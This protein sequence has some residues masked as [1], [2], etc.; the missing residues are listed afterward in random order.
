M[1]VHD[2]PMIHYY[3]NTEGRNRGSGR[4]YHAAEDNDVFL[5][6]SMNVC[7]AVPTHTHNI[8]YNN[9]NA[10]SIIEK[11]PQYEN[12][13]HAHCKD[14]MTQSICSEYIPNSL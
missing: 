12:V 2:S 9:L 4:P 5:A 10:N 3:C 7:S 14:G 6:L 1:T 13:H 8:Q 11:S